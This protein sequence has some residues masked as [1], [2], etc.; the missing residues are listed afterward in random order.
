[1]SSVSAIKIRSRGSRE[2]TQCS[3]FHKTSICFG[4]IGYISILSQKI[5]RDSTVL[6]NRALEFE[7]Y[8]INAMRK[9]L[10]FCA[11]ATNQFWTTVDGNA[12]TDHVLHLRNALL[13]YQKFY[14]S[15]LVHRVCPKLYNL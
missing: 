10:R 8:I 5:L 12:H 14:D 3:E 4:Y 11:D 7:I 2:K 9:S 15:Y 1:M 13:A 6:S